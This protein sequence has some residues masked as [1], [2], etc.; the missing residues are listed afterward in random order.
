MLELKRR[1]VGEYPR[2]QIPEQNMR[3]P[4]LGALFKKSNALGGNLFVKAPLRVRK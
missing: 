3:K 4:I 2:F 1:Q